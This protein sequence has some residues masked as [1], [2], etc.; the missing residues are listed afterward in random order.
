MNRALIATLSLALLV[1]TGTAAASAE[2]DRY[3][4]YADATTPYVEE[5][6]NGYPYAYGAAWNFPSLE[7]AEE[8][9]VRSCG[10]APDNQTGA[11]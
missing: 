8:A 11:G 2:G 4:A 3:W 6:S 7:E 9:A 10:S 5:A 1:L